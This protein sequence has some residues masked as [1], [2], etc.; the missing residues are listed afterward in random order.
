[1]ALESY[2]VKK[3]HQYP[4]ANEFWSA[5]DPNRISWSTSTCGLLLSLTTLLKQ[6]SSF[7]LV[8]R[9]NISLPHIGVPT[10]YPVSAS[11]QQRDWVQQCTTT[12]PHFIVYIQPTLTYLWT[13]PSP[14]L[15]PM[16]LGFG[17]LTCGFYDFVV[18]YWL[19]IYWTSLR[20]P[21]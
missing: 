21:M 11:Y 7:G 5:F 4:V 15:G 16:I 9:S 12:A 18:Y 14:S 10:L 8:G 19:K 17:C 1:M 2:C 6:I 3:D 20:S 13:I